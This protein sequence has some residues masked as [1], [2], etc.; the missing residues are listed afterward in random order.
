MKA[1]APNQVV[2]GGG[3]A[4]MTDAMKERA[5][6]ALAGRTGETNDEDD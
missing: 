3:A 1:G 4:G 6:E 2:D 5:K